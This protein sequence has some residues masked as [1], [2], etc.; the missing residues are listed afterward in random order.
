MCRMRSLPNRKRWVSSSDHGL[1]QNQTKCIRLC[2][3]EPEIT[4]TFLT[5]HFIFY[6]G[7]FVIYTWDKNRDLA[8]KEVRC[9]VKH[10]ISQNC[11]KLR[12]EILPDSYS[13]QQTS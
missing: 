6:N 5:V 2:P 7:Y 13:Q 10:S 9:N 1:D 4:K 3:K 11:H 12:N 8:R